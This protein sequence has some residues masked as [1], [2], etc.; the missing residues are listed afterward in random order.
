MKHFKHVTEENVEDAI[1]AFVNLALYDVLKDMNYYKR[2]TSAQDVTGLPP[3]AI[4]DLTN[5]VEAEGFKTDSLNDPVSERDWLI[6]K[7]SA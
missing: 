2:S 7:R 3:Q 4:A 1:K 6:V 5:A